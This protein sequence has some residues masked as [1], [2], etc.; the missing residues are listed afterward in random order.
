MTTTSPQAVDKK[1]TEFRVSPIFHTVK[2]PGR[3]TER[4]PLSRTSFVAG[5]RLL[6]RP[7]LRRSSWGTE[8]KD[9]EV[10]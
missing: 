10:N 5:R 4:N 3:E 2:N 8:S 1:G 9:F 6:R 7:R